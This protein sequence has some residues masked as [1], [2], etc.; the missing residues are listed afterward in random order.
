MTMFQGSAAKGITPV[1]YPAYAG[2][3]VTQRFSM[4]VPTTVANGDIL[5]LACIPPGCRPVDLVLDSDDLDTGTPAMTLDVGVMSGEWGD[6][7][8]GRTC[9]KE[10]FDAATT[11]QAG[12]VARPTLAGAYRVAGA[13][14]ARSIG[15]KIVTK[16]AT[17][18]AGEIGLTVSYVA[19]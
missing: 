9:G 18:A 1:S 8:A 2:H 15:V 4:A 14:K 16:A 11:A 5:E 10:F 12:G 6:D 17:A 13:A 7:T 3:V 19:A